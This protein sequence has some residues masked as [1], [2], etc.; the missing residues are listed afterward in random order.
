MFRAARF[1]QPDLLWGRT[2]DLLPS[3]RASPG[4]AALTLQ[5]EGI[6]ASVLATQFLPPEEKFRELPGK[7]TFDPYHDPAGFIA[8]EEQEKHL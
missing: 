3:F 7:N 4:G 6:K 1:A 8:L 2:E 5:Q